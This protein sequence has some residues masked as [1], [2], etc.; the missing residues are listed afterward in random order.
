MRENE[1]FEFLDGVRGIASFI[2][3]IHHFT[4]CFSPLYFSKLIERPTF[5]EL[6]TDY[7]WMIL[8]NGSFA[9]DLFFVH[10]G[11]VL[12][13]KHYQKFNFTHLA[14]SLVR[15]Y[16]RLTIPLAASI[17]FS[18]VILS[19]G[20]YHNREF[21]QMT[22]NKWLMGYLNFF[23]SI[24]EAIKQ[25]VY[26]AYFAFKSA[27]TYNNVLWTI[28]YELIG[29]YFIFLLLLI[30]R[31]FWLLILCFV[32]T[33]FYKKYNL[34]SFL[35]GMMLSYA[36]VNRKQIFSNKFLGTSAL[37]IGCVCSMYFK[38]PWGPIGATLM[39]YGLF[40]LTT[41]Q[42][43]FSSK[44]IARL[45]KYSFSLYLIHIPILYSFS[46]IFFQLPI[47]LNFILTTVLCLTLSHF[48]Y[49]YIDKKGIEFSHWI[50][51]KLKLS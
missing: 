7:P 51:R 44:P 47:W 50:A 30:S 25:S 15:R 6:L 10:S 5:T 11:L 33:F 29:S 9:V 27:T 41:F 20:W 26:G 43:I 46:V 48:M 31:Q 49:E 12:S 42:A 19:L 8:I 2:V 38:N 18:Y 21:G 32:G 24:S 40:S 23:P 16:I 14:S 3:F 37:I 45:G 13:F 34:N 22:Q 1:K 36:L 4:L 39:I 28:S 35:L 17:L